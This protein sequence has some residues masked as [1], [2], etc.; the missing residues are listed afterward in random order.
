MN[1]YTAK[2]LVVEDEEDICEILQFNLQGEGFVADVAYSAEEALKKDLTQ[3]NLILLDVMMGSMSGFKFAEKLRNTDFIDIPIIFITARAAENDLLTGYN[4]GGD[5]YITKPFSIKEVIARVKAVI[6]RTQVTPEDDSKMVLKFGDLKIDN[7]EKRVYI[8]EKEKELT[9]KEFEI[10]YLLV[11]NA[12]KLFSRED[13]LHK[14]WSGDVIVTLRTVD[15]HLARLRKKIGKYNRY[16]K[17]KPGYGYI[18]LTDI[19]NKNQ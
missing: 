4:L 1:K 2:I 8:D 10:L 13:I 3:Y 11:S 5:D 16:V 7:H 17:S 19:P 6:K 12:G 18:F 9:R 14:I 15:V